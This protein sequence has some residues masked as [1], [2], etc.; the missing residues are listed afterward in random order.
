MAKEDGALAFERGKLDGVD[1]TL[2]AVV[3]EDV[4]AC[5]KADR[6]S[7]MG[8]PPPP[9][10]ESMFLIT[11]GLRLRRGCMCLMAKELLTATLESMTYRRYKRERRL[12]WRA[13]F[14]CL[15]PLHGS[16]SAGNYRQCLGRKLRGCGEW[17]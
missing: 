10:P 14:V 17:D 5:A 11:K 6:S 15:R 2:V 1:G 13:A 12:D 9:I 3:G 7:G 8:I 16:N 4:E